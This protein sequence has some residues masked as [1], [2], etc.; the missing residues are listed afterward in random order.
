MPYFIHVVV[1]KYDILK[2][3]K[4]RKN[5]IKELCLNVLGWEIV[6]NGALCLEIIIK[7]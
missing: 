7:V 4:V 5:C 6:G 1:G 2:V 3:S